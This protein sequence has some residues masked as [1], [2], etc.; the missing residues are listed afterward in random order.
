MPCRSG[1]FRISGQGSS[2]ARIILHAADYGPSNLVRTEVSHT[3]ASLT[4]W[5]DNER[6]YAWSNWT[7]TDFPLGAFD[8]QLMFMEC[9]GPVYQQEMSLHVNATSVSFAT[10]PQGGSYQTRWTGMIA[11]GQWHD[12]VLHVK[13]SLD[14]AVGFVELRYDGAIVVPKF[15]MR[16]MHAVKDAA[17][18]DVTPLRS[19]MHHALFLGAF[20]A[21]KPDEVVYLDDVREGTTLADVIAAPPPDAGSPDAGTPDAG[22]TDAGTVNDAGAS[23]DAGPDDSGVASTPDGGQ[24][25]AGVAPG[26]DGGTG[27]RPGAASGC[28]CSTASGSWLALV[29]LWIALRARR[30]S[31]RHSFR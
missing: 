24:K 7:S 30:A 23:T 11:A 14:P 2:A 8:H 4:G 15:T 21:N 16:T 1:S 28:S 22:G 17:G 10:S 31:G 6:Y 3:P 19:V 9:E 26:T 25:D 27:D 13:W 18:N 12:F 5:Q 29:A 20:R